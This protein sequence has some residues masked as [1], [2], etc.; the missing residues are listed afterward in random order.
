MRPPPC[1]QNNLFV[2]ESLKLIHSAVQLHQTLILLLVIEACLAAA[3]GFGN[4]HHVA[5]CLFHVCEV[6][7]ACSTAR[8]HG[9]GGD[10]HAYDR[11]LAVQGCRMLFR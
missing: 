3:E 10:S 1:V 9:L 2:S 7:G 11:R 8:N 4:L 6:A 5:C